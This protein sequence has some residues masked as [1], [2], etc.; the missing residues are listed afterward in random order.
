M[1][2]VVIPTFEIASYNIHRLGICLGASEPDEPDLIRLATLWLKYE[3]SLEGGAAGPKDNW[4]E[5]KP[6]ATD[7]PTNSSKAKRFKKSKKLA[8]NY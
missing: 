4:A 1:K 5:N 6:G 3:H 8:A 2:H 7:L